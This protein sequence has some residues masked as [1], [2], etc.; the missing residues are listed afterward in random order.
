MDT[1]NIQIDTGSPPPGPESYAIYEHHSIKDIE[2]G[3]IFCN[4]W[5]DPY[6][7]NLAACPVQYSDFQENSSPARYGKSDWVY[8]DTLEP[9]EWDEWHRSA[10]RFLITSDTREARTTKVFSRN[11][12]FCLQFYPF[13]E[14]DE[15]F[16]CFNVSFG[17]W[18]LKLW[19][20]GF[21][22]LEKKSDS[23]A[24]ASGWLTSNSR[25][26][27]TDKMNQLVV[28]PA[29][30]DSIIVRRNWVSGFICSL[31][32]D[33]L[34]SDLIESDS[35]Y[36]EPIN[37]RLRFQLTQL[38]WDSTKDYYFISP[39]R[40]FIRPPETGQDLHQEAD[41][42]KTDGGEVFCKTGTLRTEHSTW[43]GLSDYVCDGD[44]G[45]SLAIKIEPATQFSVPPAVSGASLW[46]QAVSNAVS[47]E[48]TDYTD[49]LVSC[50]LH[51]AMRPSDSEAKIVLKDVDTSQFAQMGSANIRLNIGAQCIFDG[52]LK[53][54]PRV[55]YDQSGDHK[56]EIT[57]KTMAK[58]LEEPCLY[59][60]MRFDNYPHVFAVQWLCNYAGI[61]PD[62][63]V[64]DYDLP[65]NKSTSLQP[66]VETG[67]DGT[68]RSKL[69][70]EVGDSPSKWI[71]TICELTGWQF[72]DGPDDSGAFA[73]KYVASEHFSE[74]VSASFYT[75]SSAASPG[76][77]TISQWQYVEAG[78]FC[79]ELHVIGCT[80][81]GDRVSACYRDLASQDPEIETR[82]DNWL[83]TRKVDVL[84]LPGQ[85]TEEF[86]KSVA[87]RLGP[88]M[89][90]KTKWASFAGSWPVGLWKNDVIR[91][92]HNGLGAFCGEG[93]YRIVEM[94]IDFEYEN[95]PEPVRTAKYLLQKIEVA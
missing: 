53:S 84:P 31:E 57:A 11:T 59:S 28:M 38:F 18:K 51:A 14:Q 72:T 37:G 65:D 83:G 20:N 93:N 50:S 88:K 95:G 19:A 71:E 73:L 79:N 68:R 46:A 16:E 5:I 42:T 32:E 75:T 62:K 44:A 3:A 13:G 49:N 29:G 17:Q 40:A 63:L 47:I 24:V 1:L 43:D 10:D 61:R 2:A 52:V 81:R 86:L 41:I 69:T 91:V 70:V 77:E 87:V 66:M 92:V 15:A 33:E 82:P 85:V 45:Y 6:T 60:N 80:A 48:G 22:R 56:V 35:V 12:G 36:I 8:S 58:S 90:A 55:S 21:A 9:V 78:P 26:R 25:E 94:D 39:N 74:D 7:K 4:T 64:V 34:A 27:L 30:P 54:P 23:E 67:Q 76:N 89:C